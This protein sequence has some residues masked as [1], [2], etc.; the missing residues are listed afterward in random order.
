M[1]L[2]ICEKTMV[3]IW[4]IA[5]DPQDGLK[6]LEVVRNLNEC[7]NNNKNEDDE[8]NDEITTTTTS[9][10]T[11]AMKIENDERLECKSEV[12]RRRNALANIWNFRE[13]EISG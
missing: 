6:Y 2:R 1:K 11:T 5:V 12:L 4:N 10:S 13:E 3:N 7:N 9:T 8:C